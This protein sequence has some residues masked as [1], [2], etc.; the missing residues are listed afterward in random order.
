MEI[1]LRIKSLVSGC[2]SDVGDSTLT[3]LR[4][5]NADGPKMITSHETDGRLLL[6]LSTLIHNAQSGE[7]NAAFCAVNPLPELPGILGPLPDWDAAIHAD[8]TASV[9]WTVAGSAVS[10]LDFR[11]SNRAE[12]VTVNEQT[13]FGVFGAPRFMRSN[14]ESNLPI[15]AIALIDGETQVVVFRPNPD[16]SFTKYKT[17]EVNWRGVP[18]IAQLVRQKSGYLLFVKVLETDVAPDNPGRETGS[19]KKLM[20]GFVDVVSL[21]AEFQVRSIGSAPFGGMSVFE[22]DAVFADSLLAV[23]ATTVTGIQ[24]AILEEQEDAQGLLA[25]FIVLSVGLISAEPFTS[26]SLMVSDHDLYLAAIRAVNT[27]SVHVVVDKLDLAQLA[28]GRRS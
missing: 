10:G 27:E 15:A 25:T 2:V 4:L 28:D 5:I 16:H 12:S 8:G 24:V 26:P 3:S 20:P 22:F 21:D 23:L 7:I 11:N 14:G 6:S 9:V 19:G 17:I 13:P 1:K 18:V